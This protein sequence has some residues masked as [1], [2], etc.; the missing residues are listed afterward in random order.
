MEQR[1]AVSVKF[2]EVDNFL[3]IGAVYD[4]QCKMRYDYVMQCARLH[5]PV[6]EF[7]GLLRD[8]PAYNNI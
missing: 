7:K 3:N 8:V 2:D 5:L 6:P 4:E 1:A